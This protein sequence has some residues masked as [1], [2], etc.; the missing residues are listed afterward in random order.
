MHSC[1]VHHCSSPVFRIMSLSLPYCFVRNPT[2]TD[3]MSLTF[4][5]ATQYSEIRHLLT[6]G[7]SS[8]VLFCCY[9]IRAQLFTAIGSVIK[10]MFSLY[11][12]H[13]FSFHWCWWNLGFR[14]S[15]SATFRLPE[16]VVQLEWVQSNGRKNQE[17]LYSHHLHWYRSS[18]S[19]IFF[20]QQKKWSLL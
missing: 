11:R 15:T 1:S 10:H 7:W 8:V 6:A 14:K 5:S 3:V 2:A 12:P 4:S 9:L 19:N 20:K 16:L 13:P 17:D 18:S